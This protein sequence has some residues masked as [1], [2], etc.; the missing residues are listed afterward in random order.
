MYLLQKRWAE[1]SQTNAFYFRTGGAG[2]L[3]QWDK[4]H[5]TSSKSRVQSVDRWSALRNVEQQTAAHFCISPRFVF[6]QM[7]VQSS[8]RE[9]L[10]FKGTAI[11]A[12][13][14]Q[15]NFAKS[16]QQSP[17]ALY[18]KVDPIIHK[19]LIYIWMI[20][21]WMVVCFLPCSL[22]VHARNSHSTAG[23]LCTKIWSELHSKII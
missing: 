7:W 4:T 8:V 23:L 5:Q 3:W 21:P 17:Q 14:F 6:E 16:Q 12:C 1:L 15:F 2:F 11:R 19:W 20:D 22:Q 9:K 18:C 13:T 10:T